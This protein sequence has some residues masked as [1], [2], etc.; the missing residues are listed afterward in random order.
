LQC[1]NSRYSNVASKLRLGKPFNLQYLHSLE[2][3]KTNIFRKHRRKFKPVNLQFF[4]WR[5]VLKQDAKG[6]CCE[7]KKL[8]ALYIPLIVF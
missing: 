6:S 4:I 8:S 7:N 1:G 5:R 2:E 3:G